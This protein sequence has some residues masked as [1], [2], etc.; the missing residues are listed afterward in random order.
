MLWEGRAPDF[1]FDKMHLAEF[2]EL[3]F[4]GQASI[5]ENSLVVTLAFEFINKT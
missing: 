2:E 5:C 1:F 3:F 4:N